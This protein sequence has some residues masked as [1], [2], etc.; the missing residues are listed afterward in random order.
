MNDLPLAHQALK[1]L[2]GVAHAR[3]ALAKFL[4]VDTSFDKLRNYHFRVV[5]VES[6]SSH[7]VLLMRGENVIAHRVHVGDVAFSYS[8]QASSLKCEIVNGATLLL[9]LRLYAVAEVMDTQVKAI[10]GVVAEDESDSGQVLDAGGEPI[11]EPE[12]EEWMYTF[13]RGEDEPI[14]EGDDAEPD[15]ISDGELN[16][17]VSDMVREASPKT[18][19]RAIRAF[20]KARGVL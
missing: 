2:C 9:A 17:L 12:T 14:P 18:T 20:A 16:M 1:F 19:R 4:A 3:V 13:T 8:D 15:S 6:K 7:V 10:L 11:R 5:S